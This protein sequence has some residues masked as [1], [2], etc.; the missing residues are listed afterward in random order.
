M[1]RPTSSLRASNTH[2]FRIIGGRGEVAR[3]ARKEPRC[4]NDEIAMA[5]ASVRNIPQ[6]LN[7]RRTSTHK[8]VLAHREVSGTPCPTSSVDLPSWALFYRICM[9]H[10]VN[11]LAYSRAV[12]AC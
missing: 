6:R 10:A 3:R 12:A 2:E 8:A 4:L 9:A 5:R 7:R 1:L 11:E